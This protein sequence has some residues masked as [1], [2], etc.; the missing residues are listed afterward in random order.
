[1]IIQS[2]SKIVFYSFTISN[3]VRKKYLNKG[4]ILG[5]RRILKILHILAKDLTI[6]DQKDIAI[7]ADRNLHHAVDLGVGELQRLLGGF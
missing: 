4:F 3:K 6:V 1:M 5:L 7:H 2:I